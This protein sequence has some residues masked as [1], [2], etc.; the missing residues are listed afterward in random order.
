M[1]AEPSSTLELSSSTIS[2]SPLRSRGLI[3]ILCVIGC[4]TTPIPAALTH[5]W[6]NR[7]LSDRQNSPDDPLGGLGIAQRGTVDQRIKLRSGNLL[8]KIAK[9]GGRLT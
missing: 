4:S 3:R 7:R 8:R 1:Y 6:R 2:C 9:I 5:L